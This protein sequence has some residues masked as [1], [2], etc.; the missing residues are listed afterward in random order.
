MSARFV[1]TII[2]MLQCGIASFFCAAAY[3]FQQRKKTNQISRL[4]YATRRSLAHRKLFP[5]HLRPEFE[6]P[7]A[8][9]PDS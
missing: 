2:Y 1:M 3:E 5:G 9:L 6:H 4:P 8:H 7:P